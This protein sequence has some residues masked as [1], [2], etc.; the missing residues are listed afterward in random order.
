MQL[1]GFKN[2]GFHSVMDNRNKP[3]IFS[4]L[5]SKM[6]EEQSNPMNMNYQFGPQPKPNNFNP[7]FGPYP[8]PCP[9]P[10]IS[11][12]SK[13]NIFTGSNSPWSNF[14]S[15]RSANGFEQMLRDLNMYNSESYNPVVFDINH[16][17][18][19]NNTNS[20]IV[21][22]NTEFKNV[23]HKLP[24]GSKVLK[25]TTTSKQRDKIIQNI[26]KLGA[27]PSNS[28]LLLRVISKVNRAVISF[29]NLNGYPVY[30]SVFTDDEIESEDIIWPLFEGVELKVQLLTVDS[31]GNSLFSSEWSGQIFRDDDS[32]AGM[33]IEF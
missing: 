5:G 18:L 33:E 32:P 8:S 1:G 11:P 26:H 4:Q 10:Q 14:S 28:E 3:S 15:K 7:S 22:R 31:M 23:R 13:P 2:N 12:T 25:V 29:L 21:L 6:R 27:D 19:A 9:S 30:D 16:A 20:L 17:H 24:S